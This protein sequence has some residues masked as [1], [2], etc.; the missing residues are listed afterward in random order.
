MS[1]TFALGITAADWSLTVPEI[2][3]VSTWAA[4]GSLTMSAK[5]KI[6]PADMTRPASLST[7]LATNLAVLHMAGTPLTVLSRLGRTSTRI[8]ARTPSEATPQRASICWTKSADNHARSRSCTGCGLQC[9]GLSWLSELR[10]ICLALHRRGQKEEPAGQLRTAPVG[11][12][13]K[14][15]MRTHA[16][17]REFEPHRLWFDRGLRSRPSAARHCKGIR[18]VHSGGRL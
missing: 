4:A 16:Q 18:R 3:P 17:A 14:L 8:A 9:Q 2:V 5:A 15:D 13:A 10:P 7:N 12:R 6:M 1:I 11:T